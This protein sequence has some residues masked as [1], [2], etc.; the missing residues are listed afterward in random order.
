MLLVCNFRSQKLSKTKCNDFNIRQHSHSQQ[1]WVEHVT[2]LKTWFESFFF[3]KL[4]SNPPTIRCWRGHVIKNW[5]SKLQ[6][7]ILGFGF[8][9]ISSKIEKYQ[10]QFKVT[11]Q[12][13]TEGNG[14]NE[15]VSHMDRSEVKLWNSEK[16]YC[17]ISYTQGDFET[18][19]FHRKWVWRG[20]KTF[21][22]FFLESIFIS[23]LWGFNSDS[24]SST[25]LKF[26]CFIAK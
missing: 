10:W 18:E 2:S 7:Y 22:S 12:L 16:K 6:A 17:D 26:G 11:V 21:K 5:V 24:F 4:N 15:I 19:R 14:R 9:E 25:N 1:E 23:K 13:E 3:F 8:L 20:A